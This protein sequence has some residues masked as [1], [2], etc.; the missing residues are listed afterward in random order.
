MV[1][2]V[3]VLGIASA[4]TDFFYFVSD[5]GDNVMVHASFAA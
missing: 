5:H 3:I 2:A 1:L 4:A